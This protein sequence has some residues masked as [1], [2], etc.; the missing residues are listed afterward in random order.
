M[1]DN[2]ILYEKI[3]SPILLLFI[4]VIPLSLLLILNC[5]GFYFLSGEIKSDQI[6]KVIVLFVL[7]ILLIVLPSAAAIFLWIKKR[8]VPWFLFWLIL[9]LAIVYLVTFLFF[10][11]TLFPSTLDWWIV[12]PFRIVY[13]QFVFMLPLVFYSL[14]NL[15]LFSISFSVKKDIIASIGI[16]IA[17]PIVWY[18]LFQIAALFD[19]ILNDVSY[20]LVMFFMVL[21][22]LLLFL[23]LIRITLR[24]LNAFGKEDGGFRFAFVFCIS[25]VLPIGGLLLNTKIQFPVDLQIPAV[26]LFTVLNAVAV[27]LPKTSIDFINSILQKIRI[28][29]YPFSIYFFILFLPFLP[30]SIPA[31]IFFGGGFLILTP[32]LL[33]LI[34]TKL[35]YDDFQ[36]QII[37]I[38]KIISSLGLFLIIPGVLIITTVFDKIQ[39]NNALDYVYESDYVNHKT[40]KGNRFF[41]KQALKGMQNMKEGKFLPFI[42]GFYNYVVFENL[43]LPDNKSDYL[44]KVFFGNSLEKSSRNEIQFFQLFSSNTTN[45]LINRPPAP[46]SESSKVI[47]EEIQMLGSQKSNGIVSTRIKLKIKSNSTRQ[48][49]EFRTVIKI[50]QHVVISG[51]SLDI[52]GDMVPGQLFE[53]KT[54]LWV[55]QMITE[56]MRDPALLYYHTKEELRLR[57][58]PF[59]KDETRFVEIEFTFP[60][61]A[62]TEIQIGE[63][64]YTL[65]NSDNSTLYAGKID[66]SEFHAVVIPAEIKTNMKKI[67]RQPIPYII[68]DWSIDGVTSIYDSEITKL[69]KKQQF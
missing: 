69:I 24:I 39:L 16:T 1:N 2:S 8:G 52:N 25:L 54:A 44:H 31:M 5:S 53:K 10:T 37:S 35:I 32:T 50:P 19:K 17:I 18:L 26:Y 57:V 3:K 33:F 49:D 64:I 51:F 67:K 45:P 41:L 27:S 29:L 15:A 38:R 11:D 68:L 62:Q 7:L 34:H 59:R 48:M 12:S 40:F 47:L 63:R 65:N 14:V 28:A 21:T 55:Y 60:L 13:F 42:T 58:F 43:V 23:L 66:D 22:T 20:L 9:I 30:L 61:N 4:T 56:G 46:F 6:Y 36:F